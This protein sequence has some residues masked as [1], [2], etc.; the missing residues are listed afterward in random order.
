MMMIKLGS[1]PQ[2]QN[3]QDADA[4]L[5]LHDID[6]RV[7][8]DFEGVKNVGIDFLDQIFKVFQNNNPELKI[9]YKNASN[10]ISNK[11]YVVMWC[12]KNDYPYLDEE[13]LR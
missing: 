10:D 12:D 2:L 7:T 5:A 8:V 4:I 9:A 11:I 6:R 13:V 1:N 3:R